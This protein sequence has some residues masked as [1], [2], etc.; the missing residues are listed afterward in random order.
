MTVLSLS[1]LGFL[2]VGYPLTGVEAAARPKLALHLAEDKPT[3]QCKEV[4]VSST[5]QKVYLYPEALLTEKDVA[6]ATVTQTDK[7]LLAISVTFTEEGGKKMA[8]LT[9]ANPS[10]RLALVVDGKVLNAPVIRSII[11]DRAI[12]TGK[13][14]KAEAEKIAK[15]INPK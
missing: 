2:V 6:K 4:T 8:K 14:T 13:F 9:K 5:N 11:T 3:K 10:K 1:L 7:G 12:I 15:E